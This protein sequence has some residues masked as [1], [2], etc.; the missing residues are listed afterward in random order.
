PDLENL[1]GM[2]QIQADVAWSITTGS[3]N[4]LVGV[5]DSGLDYNHP[6]LAANAAESLGYN[7]LNN[8]PYWWYDTPD[9]LDDYGHG[10]H[11]SGIIGATGDNGEGVI[12]VNWDVTLIPLKIWDGGGNG[13]EAELIAALAY[14]ECLEIPILNISGGWYG[15]GNFQAMRDAVEAYSG[16]IVAAAGNGSNDNDDPYEAFYPAA[17]GCANILAVAASDPA[18]QLTA[19]SGYG[20]ASV[21]L[22][23]P[24]SDILSTVDYWLWDMEQEWYTEPGYEA[25]AGTSMAAAHVAGAAALLQAAEP[26]LSAAEIKAAIINT[27]DYSAELN[28]L[29]LSNGRLNVYAALD[30]L[31]TAIEQ[32]FI[33]IDGVSFPITWGCGA[34]YDEYDDELYEL[35]AM[36]PSS[37]AQVCAYTDPLGIYGSDITESVTWSSSNTSVAAIDE[38]GLITAAANEEIDWED[39]ITIISAGYDNGTTEITAKIYVIVQWID[40]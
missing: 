13:S 22:A 14:A 37:T 6:A 9:P 8:N 26:N 12:G 28:G 20:A 23:A 11:V 10:T 36:L 30:S 16:L 15:S 32:I 25:W 34:Y 40:R 3:H 2:A 35:A 5:L 17:F 1:W 24:G 31:N 18:D 7:F 29:V 4:V 38:Y 39:N 21:D 27:V 19:F 33:D